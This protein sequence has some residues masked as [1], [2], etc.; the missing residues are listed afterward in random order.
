MPAHNHPADLY[1]GWRT[2]GGNSVGRVTANDGDLNGWGVKVKNTGG[3]GAHENRQPYITVY[4]W[5][6]TA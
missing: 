4:M 1:L 3:G 6:R 5:K 2:G